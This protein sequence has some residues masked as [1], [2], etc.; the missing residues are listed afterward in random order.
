MA[1]F[2]VL[3]LSFLSLSLSLSLAVMCARNRPS[4]FAEKLYKSM[5]GL[6]TDDNTLI[7]IVVTRAEVSHCD[8]SLQADVLG[9]CL[10]FFLR[11]G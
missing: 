4:Y 9:D 1:D 2:K 11:C 3:A 10:V 6:G 8:I 7:R 5:K